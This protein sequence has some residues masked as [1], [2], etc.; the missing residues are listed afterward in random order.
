MGLLL[1]HGMQFNHNDNDHHHH[2]DNYD[3]QDMN[4]LIIGCFVVVVGCLWFGTIKIASQIVRGTLDVFFFFNGIDCRAS[5]D[6]YL[7]GVNN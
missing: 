1:R 2:N 4:R 6:K 5:P 3:H 7:S